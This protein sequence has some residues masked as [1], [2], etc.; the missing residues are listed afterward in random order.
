MVSKRALRH[1]LSPLALSCGLSCQ[2]GY[3][4]APT[5]CDDWCD[6]NDRVRCGDYL[7]DPA[8]CV[9]SCEETQTSINHDCKTALNAA[10]E[11]LRN[12]PAGNAYCSSQPCSSEISAVYACSST[13]E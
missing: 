8:S 1:A 2:G 12:T 4:I 13:Q 9:A 3:P 5:L 10:V 11:C 7:E 6:A